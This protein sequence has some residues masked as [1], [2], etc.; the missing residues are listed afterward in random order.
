M[1]HFHS[2]FKLEPAVKIDITAGSKN[3]SATKI[4]LTFTN[5]LYDHPL[6]KGVFT[7]GWYHEL[8]TM[9]LYKKL[10]NVF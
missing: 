2:R 1:K 6:V 4:E 8:A 7:N 5:G 10:Y 3:E 9:D